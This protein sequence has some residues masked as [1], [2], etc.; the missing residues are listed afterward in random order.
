VTPHWRPGP[1]NW[2]GKVVAVVGIGAVTRLMS[3]ATWGSMDLRELFDEFCDPDLWSSAFTD[4]NRLQARRCSRFP[5]LCPA[6]RGLSL[7][8][9]PL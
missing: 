8:A 9:E 1:H 7:G 3:F 4:V 6:R 2:R 5:T